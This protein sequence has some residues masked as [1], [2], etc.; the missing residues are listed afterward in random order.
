MSTDP[1][2]VADILAAGTDY[3]QKQGVDQPRL[4]CELLLA[5]LL[6]C[7]RLDLY[8]K[9]DESLGERHL[10][11]MRRGIRRVAGGEPVQYVTR[12]AGFMDDLFTVDRRVLV[13]RPETEVLVRAVLDCGPLW[14]VP[15]P[16]VV[17]VGTGSG[18]IV[19][20]LAKARP[21]GRYIGL[22][23]SAEALDVARINADALGLTDTVAFAQGELP[24]I[25]EPESL[26]AIVANLP[27]IPSAD[28]ERLAP[29][30]KDH[31]PR[32]ALDGG[33]DGLAVIETVIADAVMALQPGGRIFLEI[34]EDQ[35]AAVTGRL[36]EAGF[37]HVSIHPDLNGRDRIAVAAVPA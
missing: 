6:D 5:R 2:T 19:L 11:A 16:A 23:T 13:P 22:D 33:A 10:A 32:A 20:S 31:E 30:V 15:H 9:H 24:D 7:R 29:G 3:L 26:N 35:G 21:Q 12:Q 27:Y 4:A 34:G 25:V 18:C 37:E 36:K 17:D 28:I 8:L 1:K 14:D